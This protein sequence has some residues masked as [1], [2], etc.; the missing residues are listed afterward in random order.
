VAVR[1]DRSTEPGVIRLEGAIDIDRAAELKEAL[2]EA[3]ASGQAVRISLQAATSIDVTAV[4]LLWAAERE[5]GAS[6]TVLAL[7]GAVPEIVRATLS[8]A[9]F[10]RFPFAEKAP[11]VDKGRE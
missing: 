10:E 3:L 1:F 5:A 11:G 4:Q 7:E 2:L 9:G 6:G 8:E